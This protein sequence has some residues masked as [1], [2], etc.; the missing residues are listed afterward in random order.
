MVSGYKL[1]FWGLILAHVNFTVGFFTLFPAFVGY[2]VLLCGYYD[3][4]ANTKKK[5]YLTPRICTA[6]LVLITIILPYMEY[7]MN[8]DIYSTLNYQ[9]YQSVLMLLE[10]IVV[11]YVFEMGINKLEREQLNDTARKFIRKD[12][13][14]LWLMGLGLC[15]V[16]IGVTA[17]TNYFQ[18]VALVGNTLAFLASVVML[19]T[20]SDFKTT[21]LENEA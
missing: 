16:T 6:L 4:E 21:F 9:Y 5:R 3:I 11:H 19:F 15:G 13:V 1:V 12:K 14:F 10:L 18:I 17:N 2:I 20:L 8:M 7:F